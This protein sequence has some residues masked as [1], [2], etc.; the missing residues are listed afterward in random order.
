MTNNCTLTRKHELILLFKTKVQ[1]FMSNVDLT[2]GDRKCF[3]LFDSII[4]TVKNNWN[5]SIKT[6]EAIEEGYNKY[7][8]KDMLACDAEI[9]AIKDNTL[10]VFYNFSNYAMFS[11]GDQFMH[12]DMNSLLNDNNHIEA[13]KQLI[14][15][16]AN[17]LS[18]KTKALNKYFTD[19]I[20]NRMVNSETRI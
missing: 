16:D 6:I 11:D 2:D 10:D 17:L 14:M 15:T 7:C 9:V 19:N 8:T 5:L 12:V 13:Y 3:C 20:K 1:K 4:L 18:N